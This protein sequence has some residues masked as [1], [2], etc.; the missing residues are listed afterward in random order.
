MSVFSHDF[1]QRGAEMMGVD[2][3][4]SQLFPKA[5]SLG[6]TL[7]S[8]YVS[9]LGTERVLPGILQTKYVIFPS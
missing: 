8:K 3:N 2:D 6:R 4:Q 1:S 7:I 5:D 9:F